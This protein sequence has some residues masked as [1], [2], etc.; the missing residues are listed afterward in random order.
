[1]ICLLKNKTDKKKL[2]FQSEKSNGKE[3]SEF[4]LRKI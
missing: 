2:F 4:F 1:M 3:K